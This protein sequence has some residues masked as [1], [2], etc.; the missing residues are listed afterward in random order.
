MKLDK[1][2]RSRNVEDRRGRGPS[3]GMVG[4]GIGALLVLVIASLIGIDPGALEG[5]IPSNEPATPYDPTTGD[6]EGEFVSIVLGETELTW[7]TIFQQSGGDYREPTLVMFTGA[8]QSACGFAQA[9]VGPFYCPADEKVYLDTSF[10]D[11]LSTR[12]GAP[13]D[14][15]R[16]YVIAHEVGHHVQ[17]LIGIS[18]EVHRL[19]SSVS[20]E[21]A[22]QL[23][24]L[25]ELQA[26]C[27]A[28]V[29]AH[30]AEQ[31]RNIL[32]EG[33][34][35]EGLGAA[36]AVGDDRLQMQAQGYVVP[37]SFTHGSSGQRQ[38][39]FARGYQTGSIN[40]CDTFASLR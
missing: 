22:N 28:G 19:R 38:E 33:D 14:F 11:D 4:G 12:F 26:D 29:W 36:S 31:Q 17:N 16:A 18:S 25:Q 7:N 6:A 5:V 1:S 39:W 8:V 13:G 23:S 15:A 20:Q 9:A 3:R 24:V 32:E 27:F 40:D 21:Q 2:R 10:F 30:F 35:Q 37:E 34:V